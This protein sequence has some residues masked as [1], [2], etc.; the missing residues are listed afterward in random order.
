M[1]SNQFVQLKMKLIY[2]V[3][4]IRNSMVCTTKHN[5]KLRT[6]MFYKNQIKVLAKWKFI[7]TMSMSFH[8]INS[9]EINCHQINSHKINL[10]R[11]Q[12]LQ[13]QWPYLSIPQHTSNLK[14][15]KCFRYVS[16][17]QGWVQG[18]TVEPPKTDFPYYGNLHNAD[19][20]PRSWVIPYTI[21]YVHKETSILRTPPK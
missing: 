4:I 14:E 16:L 19:K 18:A 9:H 5:F 10:P 8:E 12:L 15:G 3:R 6:S 20:S 2:F 17:S 13:D 7:L 11:D 1:Y 21:V